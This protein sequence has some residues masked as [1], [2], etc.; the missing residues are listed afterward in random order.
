MYIKIFQQ[1][2]RAFYEKFALKIERNLS[3]NLKSRIVTH[4]ICIEMYRGTRT[5]GINFHL[6]ESREFIAVFMTMYRELPHARDAIFFNRYNYIDCG[7]A[8]HCAIT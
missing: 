3:Q 1:K 6:N 7:R 4:P 2:K 5:F 8:P